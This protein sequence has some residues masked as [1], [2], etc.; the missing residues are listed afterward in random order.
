MAS[1][2]VQPD[3]Q[4][5]H[6]QPQQQQQPPQQARQPAQQTRPDAQGPT[7]PKPSYYC[8]TCSLECGRAD[9]LARHLQG[10][11]HAAKK[12]AM[13][14]GPTRNAPPPVLYKPFHTPLCIFNGEDGTLYGVFKLEQV[15]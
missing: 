8:G 12:A 3:P 9:Y 1:G 14:C 6:A 10:V 7:S 5:V 13:T 15:Q 2:P 11:R 4:Q